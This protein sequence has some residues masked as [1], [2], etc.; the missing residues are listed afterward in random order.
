M[1]GDVG[2]DPGSSGIL[3]SE[4][5]A[6]GARGADHRCTL[7]L[8]LFG[9]GEGAYRSEVIPGFWLRVEWLWQE[10]LPKVL[11]VLREMELIRESQYEM[12][13]CAS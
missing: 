7:R 12:T 6:G 11:D 10:P 5:V 4:A 2:F 1:G 8:R 9:G 3:S 13:A